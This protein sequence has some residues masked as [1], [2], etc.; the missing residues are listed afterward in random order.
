MTRDI[1]EIKKG[2][3]QAKAALGLLEKFIAEY[4]GRSV[5]V[6]P[7]EDVRFYRADDEEVIAGEGVGSL[8][9]LNEAIRD[10]ARQM[11]AI[12]NSPTSGRV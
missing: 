6:L 3:A 10:T 4:E 2:I 5:N 8:S 12:D 1:L 9:S 11:A 7:C